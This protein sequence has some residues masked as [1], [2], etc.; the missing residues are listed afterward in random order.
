MATIQ[1]SLF[2]LLGSGFLTDRYAADGVHLR[3]MFDPR[4][5]FPR[6]A[7]CLFRRPAL[8]TRGSEE[9]VPHHA[10]KWG[11]FEAIP[12][13][14][15]PGLRVRES[16]G[17]SFA[18]AQGIALTKVPLLFELSL[19]G[20]ADAACYVRFQLRLLDPGG[21]ATAVAE[22]LHHDQ[23]EPVDRASVQFRT[24]RSKLG[25]LLDKIPQGFQTPKLQTPEQK[26]L[27]AHLLKLDG[28]RYRGV[29]LDWLERLAGVLKSE[30]IALENLS[31]IGVFRDVELVVRADRI[32]RVALT[33]GL[34]RVLSVTWVTSSQYIQTK[35]W[36]RVA[37]VPAA[38]GD[39]DYR[40]RNEEVFAGQ[41]PE[42]LAKQRVLDRLP[43]GAEPLDAPI[44]PPSRPPTDQER[45]CR[46][47]EPWRT[48]LAPWFQGVL[49][50]SAGGVQHMMQV[51]RTVPMT[52]LGQRPGE[53][54]PPEAAG[55]T[56]TVK[57]YNMLLAAATAF[58]VAQLL[59][60]A[61]I[62]AQDV[63]IAQTGQDTG[64][65]DYL[66]V[67]RWERADV[68]A[69]AKKLFADLAAAQARAASASPADVVSA[70]AAVL[71]AVMSIVGALGELN[72]LLAGAG[73]AGLLLYGLKLHLRLQ[74]APDFVG[75][76]SL[77]PTFE[78]ASVVEPSKGI[79]R[80]DWPL[81]QRARAMVSEAIPLGAC[82]ARGP[83][84]DKLE[85]VLNPIMPT[86]DGCGD[87]RAAI[88][89]AGPVGAAGTAGTASY[90]DRAADEGVKYDYGV[91][92]MDPFGRWSDFTR[93]P[94]LWEDR[95]APAAPPSAQ[96]TLDS[97]SAGLRLRVTFHWDR[98]RLPP[99][100]FAFELGLRRNTSLTGGD[101][102]PEDASKRAYWSR[103]SR[104]STGATGPFRFLGSAPSGTT[105]THD[106]LAVTITFVDA[107]IDDGAG[108]TAPR[109]IYTVELVGALE[110]TRDA[111]LRARVYAGVASQRLAYGVYSD[112]VAGPALAEHTDPAIPATPELPPD[113]LSASYADAEGLSTFKLTWHGAANTRYQVLRA[114]ERELVAVL[115][116][117]DSRVVAWRAATTVAARAEQLRLMAPSARK[118]FAPVSDWLPATSLSSPTGV[119]KLP[120]PPTIAPGDRTHVD[121]LPG[122]AD[123]LFLYAVLGRSASGEPSPWPATKDGFAAVQ[124]PVASPPTQPVVVRASWQPP[125]DLPPALAIEGAARAELLVVEPE[126]GVAPGSYELYRAATAADAVDERRMRRIHAAAPDWQVDGDN[127]RFARFVDPTV[128]PWKTYWYS[129]VAR[130]GTLSAPGMRSPASRPVAVQTA[131]PTAPAAPVL[132]TPTVSGTGLT[133]DVTVDFPT[134]ELARFR[135]E[136][137]RTDTSPRENVVVAAVATTPTTLRLAANT[138]ALPSGATVV[139]RIVDPLG[140]VGE[141][142]PL[143]LT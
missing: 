41:S 42:D 31:K 111:F 24:R 73:D 131:A 44:V 13:L 82:I 21:S 114:A 83:A 29:K 99:S 70:Q 56:M 20:P 76:A 43:H 95:S 77:T 11:D 123:T 60:L 80:V 51:T 57:P 14:D 18:S 97:I 2:K 36:T 100:G 17:S 85:D 38:G 137:W 7:V 96:A 12:Q 59:G 120:V 9:G 115:P 129:L 37:C 10:Q 138:S 4:L 15:F 55:A 22:Y 46:Y 89:P 121:R 35:G 67:G 50:E 16:D 142:A 53:A 107:N 141:S 133:V 78:E 48:T 122:R 109:R 134:T 113:P 28:A 68:A 86:V 130:A 98:L 71:E 62:D 32:D 40:K 25:D 30:N 84:G 47:L 64:R 128:A 8:G 23:A 104:T 87:V 140:R 54:L 34:A 103:F 66:A 139:V 91:S 93:A 69:W 90:T 108:G 3:W 135:V 136:L 1:P 116:A 110:V 124:V 88:L 92:E 45:V 75:P 39:D 117:T 102:W 79:V 61:Y 63:K 52:D 33:G 105:T 125:L 94:F 27:Y 119:G 81:R 126:K 132:G 49:G 112:D 58:P 74:Q 5:G 143:A 106:G 72:A 6:T 65:W 118:V 26:K 127:P 19:G 101:V